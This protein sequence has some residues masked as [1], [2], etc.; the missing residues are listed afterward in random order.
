MYKTFNVTFKQIDKYHT[1]ER[2]NKVKALD[3]SHAERL[4]LASQDGLKTNPEAGMFGDPYMPNGKIKI[5]KTKEV[6]H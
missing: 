5:V 6:K 1:F 2:N 3:S 4:I